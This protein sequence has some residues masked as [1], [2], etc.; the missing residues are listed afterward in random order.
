M[1]AA[2][3]AFVE[4]P[5]SHDFAVHHA[6]VAT[7]HLLKAYLAGMHPALI[8]DGRHF[9][10]LLHATGLGSHAGP[11]A[12]VKTI[13]LVDAY[14]RVA[15]LLP[16]KI[17]ISKED[18][19]PLADAR[20][21]V[22]HS[23]IHDSGRSG[24]VFTTCLRLVDPVLEELKVDPNSYWGPYLGLHDKLVDEQVR[25][26][27]VA[28]E[29]LLVKARSLF[30]QRFGHM[31]P[32]EREVVLAAITSKPMITMSREAPVKCPSCGSQ[33]WMAGEVEAIYV[34]EGGQSTVSPGEVLLDPHRFHCAACDLDVGVNLLVHLGD[35][36][37]GIFLDADPHYY[38]NDEPSVDEDI[39]RGR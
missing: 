31:S 2:L 24:A 21:G 30:E 17:P 5:E 3:A 18:L 16:G 39:Y 28:V 6:G 34:Y 35:L 13:G 23:A 4:G 1:N 33:G 37:R 10:S 12:K 27:R 36:P 25:Q 8:V 20:N 26:E 14:V 22:A 7:E 29:S 11:L 38:I 32:T 19:E 15:K 9:D